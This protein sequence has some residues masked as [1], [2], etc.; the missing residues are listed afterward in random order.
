MDCE[1]A[2]RVVMRQADGEDCSPGQLSASG[3]HLRGCRLCADQAVELAALPPLLDGAFE[4]H[5]YDRQFADQVVFSLAQQRVTKGSWIVVRRFLAAAVVVAAAFAAVWLTQKQPGANPESAMAGAT[6]LHAQV[7]AVG[8][9]AL[10]RRHRRDSISGS[11]V[12]AG[13]SVALRVGD[14]LT[15]EYGRASVVVGNRVRVEVRADTVVE[16]EQLDSD[17]VVVAMVDGP[18]EVFVKVRGDGAVVRVRTPFSQSDVAG[19]AF[20][21]RV[22]GA[23]AVTSV[24][25]GRVLVTSVATGDHHEV[26][27]G[28]QALCASGLTVRK[29]DLGHELG[30]IGAEAEGLVGIGAPTHPVALKP[31]VAVQATGRPEQPAASGGSGTTSGDM[32]VRAPK[33]GADR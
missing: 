2:L 32:P 29:T 20:G 27:A 14:M 1:A 17:R 5:P 10:V 3:E 23:E 9:R 8:E 28:Q 31:G 22:L 13:S 26:L 21:V 24:V 30:W 19:T 25:R 15:V 12:P 6:T 18:G 7:E 33:E 16:L 4:S 11:Y